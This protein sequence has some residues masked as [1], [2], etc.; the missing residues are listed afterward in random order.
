MRF[1]LA[2]FLY[3]VVHEGE[4]IYVWDVWN[5][6]NFYTWS[7]MWVFYS[8]MVVCVFCVFCVW[9]VYLIFHVGFFSTHISYSS[10]CNWYIPSVIPTQPYI[11]IAHTNSSIQ[12]FSLYALHFHTHTNSPITRYPSHFCSCFYLAT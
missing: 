5:F 3:L 12:H 8:H 10:H 11:T 2:C 1:S 7:F 9:F 4:I 6:V